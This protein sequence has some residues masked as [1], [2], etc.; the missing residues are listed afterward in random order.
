LPALE[1]FFSVCWTHESP[2]R[3]FPLSKPRSKNYFRSRKSPSTTRAWKIS[4][5][6]MTGAWTSL[7][8]M[9]KN[10]GLMSKHIHVL[11]LSPFTST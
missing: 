11:F 2:R 8:A 5:Y 10:R 7:G 4:W 9:W 1:M 3:Q 6:I